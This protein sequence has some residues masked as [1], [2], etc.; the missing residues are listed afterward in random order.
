MTVQSSPATLGTF[1]QRL[2]AVSLVIVAALTLWQLRSLLLLVFAAI[3]FA[4]VLRSLADL[5]ARPTG[6]GEG[7]SFVVAT[8]AAV[9]A[10]A[11]FV[12]MLGAQLQAQLLELWDRLPELLA[13]VE[14]WLG[15]GD[16]GEWL[17]ERAEAMVS[18]GAV[19]SRIAGLSGWAATLLANVLLVAAAGLYIGFRPGMY[20]GGVLALFPRRARPAAGATMDALGSALQRWLMGQLASMVVVGTLTF[21]GLWVIGLEASLALA[22]IAGL[23]EFI[24]FFGPVLATVPALALALGV[25]TTTAIWVLLLYLGIQ[26]FEGNVLN[27]LI[28]Q[29]A[30]SLPPAV[31]MF[32]LLAFGVLFGPLG[33]LLATPLAVVCLVVVKQIWTGRVLGEPVSLPGKDRVRRE[34]AGPAQVMQQETAP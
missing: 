27:P 31:T 16:V 4:V 17:V 21:L 18:E 8:A 22:F 2:V 20:R 11:V 32:A 24:P 10:V 12:T 19:M 28:Q 30:V 14:T 23:L 29:Q 26:Q 9:V 1:T 13:P 5:L 3:L 25:D 7:W 15:S 6:L 34:Q 33:V